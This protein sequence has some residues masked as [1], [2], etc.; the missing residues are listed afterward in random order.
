MEQTT[1]NNKKKG[2]EKFRALTTTASI[3]GEKK[4]KIKAKTEFFM[5]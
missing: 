1:N 5:K 4:T 3:R 2:P